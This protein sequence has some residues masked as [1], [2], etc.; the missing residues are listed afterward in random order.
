MSTFTLS[1]NAGG[2]LTLPAEVMEQLQ[3]R[4]GD[5]LTLAILEHSLELTKNAHPFGNWRSISHDLIEER[6]ADAA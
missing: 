6:A 5:E 3:I 1:V 2:A 4:S